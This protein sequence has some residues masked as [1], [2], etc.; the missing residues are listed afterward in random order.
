MGLVK[1]KS[2]K[3]FCTGSYLKILPS[4]IPVKGPLPEASKARE[5]GPTVVDGKSYL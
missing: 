4:E 3:L 2:K 1:A 5:N